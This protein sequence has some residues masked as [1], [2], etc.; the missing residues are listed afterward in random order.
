MTIKVCAFTTT[1]WSAD[2]CR[3]RIRIVYDGYNNVDIPPSYPTS[4]TLLDEL[5]FQVG[6][7]DDATWIF[8][9]IKCGPHD[10]LVLL[11]SH[12]VAPLF[13]YSS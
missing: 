6:D 3:T 11:I 10:K 1:D 4:Q 5:E 7:V 8:S 9:D 12:L 2:K 13:S